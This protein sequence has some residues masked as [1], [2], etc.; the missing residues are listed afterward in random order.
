MVEGSYKSLEE[1]KQ[2]DHRPV[3]ALYDLKVTP[4]AACCLN[5]VVISPVIY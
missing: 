5:Y 3:T 4:M 2:S 1:F